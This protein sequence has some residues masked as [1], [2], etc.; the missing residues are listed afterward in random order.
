MA[1]QVRLELTHR[2]INPMNGFQD[3]NDTNFALLLHIFLAEKIGFEPTHQVLPWLL[4]V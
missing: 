1:E 4:I 2:A 3:R